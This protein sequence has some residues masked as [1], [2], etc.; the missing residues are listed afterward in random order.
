MRVGLVGYGFGGRYFHA[1]LIAALDGVE[2]A[3]VVTRSPDRRSELTGDLGVSAPPAFDSVAD[4]VAAGVDLVTVS[5]PPESRGPVIRELLDA[6]VAVVSDKPFAM[7]FDEGRS[8]ADHAAALGVPLTVFHNRRWD[9]EALTVARAV[10]DGLVGVIRSCES[11]LDRWEPWVAETSTGGGYLLDLGSHLVDQVRELF[12]P[13][14]R[15]LAVIDR[16]PGLPL[17]TGFLL[18]LEHESG[19]R[20]RVTANCVQAAEYPRFRLTGSA[21]TLI[22]EG[23]DVQTEQVLDGMSPNDDAWGVEPAHRAGVLHRPDGTLETVARERGDWSAFYR[24]TVDALRTGAPLPVSIDGALATL[25][26][27][28]AAVESDRTGGWVVPRA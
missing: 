14:S 22:L 15:V 16:T 1:P 25:A 6:G 28:E 27:L 24:G 26:I 10:A 2:F 4:L 21:G 11:N 8:L 12:G 9:S 17:E 13:V 18:V 7:T 23:L 3:G 19:L 5:I 20:T